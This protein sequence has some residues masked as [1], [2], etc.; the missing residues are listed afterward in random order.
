MPTLSR[1]LCGS[2]KSQDR[3]PGESSQV[4]SVPAP[5]TRQQR[6][7]QARPA[8]NAIGSWIRVTGLILLLTSVPP[9]FAKYPPSAAVV[10]VREA[11]YLAVGDGVTDD[12]AALQAALNAFPNGN[13]VIYLPDGVYLVSNTL[14]W[15]VGTG[16]NEWKR[17]ILEGESTSGTIIRLKDAT[18]GFDNKAAR[19]PVVFTGRSPA[20]RF[21]NAVRSLTIDVGSGNPGAS[22]LQFNAS[23][24][25]T[26]RDVHLRAP[27]DSGDTGLDMAFTG[28]IGPLLVH[29]LTVSGFDYGVRTGDAINGQ[30]FESLR[31]ENQR[32]AGIFNA[33]QMLAIHRLRSR[34]TV[35]TLINGNLTSGTHPGGGVTLVNADID[36]SGAPADSPAIV[37]R[38]HLHL[39]QVRTR[40]FSQPVV[41]N[42]IAN[43]APPPA[44]P[45]VDAW[46]SR[47]TLTL[48]G[49]PAVPLDLPI[50]DPPAIP[51]EEDFSR[52]A[53]PVDFGAV[54]STSIDSTAGFQ[55]AVDSGATTLVLPGGSV[56]RIDGTVLLRGNIRRVIGLE[57]RLVG[58]GTLRVVDG[59]APAVSIE[60]L[61]A[62]SGSIIGLENAS[63]RTVV[64][65]HLIVGRI[66]SSTSASVFLEDVAC[67][68]IQFTGAGARIWARQVN[69][70]NAT[71]DGLVNDGGFLWVLGLKT[72]R[73]GVKIRTRSGGQTEV[74]GA[75]IYATSTTKVNPLFIVEEGKLGL[76]GVVESSFAGTPWQTLVEATR[77]GTTY[78]LLRSAVYGRGAANGFALP[79]FSFG[80]SSSQQAYTAWR[81][82][83]FANNPAD[84]SPQADP[85]GDGILNGIEFLWN[86]DPT[87]RDWPAPA[88][89]Q[90]LRM[91]SGA[92]EFSFRPPARIIQVKTS[93]NLASWSQPS[94]RSTRLSPDFERWVHVAD[95]PEV[96]APFFVRLEGDPLAA[97]P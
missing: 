24:Q 7:G 62:S 68:D 41:S 56:F 51:W 1:T 10:N 18:P 27:D 61:Y 95:P 85:D 73:A 75:H 77:D 46:S 21:R 33:G 87:I 15:P 42:L 92:L 86:S 32:I 57:G 79:H 16:G 52:W 28:E 64:F 17:T 72:E 90:L 88:H 8:T 76:T 40:G 55:A 44:G 81:L 22:A 91:E 53:N 20:Q 37:N 3:G 6:F 89:S 12:T 39:R 5:G 43:G 70:E 9:A 11:P 84:S 23:N 96:A 67:S 80:A 82:W 97:A 13:R 93:N 2:P 35:P 78:T 31:L 26:V 63:E 59:T 94:W 74:L 19:K 69:P 66:R 4:S 14:N 83:R 36:G 60:R 38:A 34:N 30:T 29:N 47:P 71:G 45:D 25:G 54:I 48:A 58:N 65:S 50:S 49:D